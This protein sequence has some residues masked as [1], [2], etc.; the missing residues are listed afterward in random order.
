MTER[1]Q[2]AKDLGCKL[3]ETCG[4]LGW[5]CWFKTTTKCTEAQLCNADMTCKKNKKVLQDCYQSIMDKTYDACSRI[6]PKKNTKKNI[7]NIKI[8]GNN[9]KTMMTS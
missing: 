4:F 8:I 9:T 3:P 6:H 5:R 7:I 1:K 2:I